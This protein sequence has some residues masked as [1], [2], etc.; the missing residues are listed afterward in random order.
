MFCSSSRHVFFSLFVTGASFERPFP[1]KPRSL[2]SQEPRN[3]SDFGRGSLSQQTKLSLLNP[4]PSH[5][6]YESHTSK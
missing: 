5:T 2:R 3:W 6:N 4:T 1:A